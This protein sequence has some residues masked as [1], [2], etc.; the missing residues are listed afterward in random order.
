MS[1]RALGV[2]CGQNR[3]VHLL[4]L[5]VQLPRS[6]CPVELAR[7]QVPLCRIRCHS[8]GEIHRLVQTRQALGLDVA[9]ALRDAHLTL[10]ACG[11]EALLSGLGLSLALLKCALG[12]NHLP[13]HLLVELVF[14]FVQ[15]VGEVLLG[16]FDLTAELLNVLRRLCILHD[17]GLIARFALAGGDVDLA[18]WMDTRLLRGDPILADVSENGYARRLLAD[19]ARRLSVQ[20]SQAGLAGVPRALPFAALGCSTALRRFVSATLHVGVIPLVCAPYRVTSCHCPV[21]V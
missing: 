3:L 6:F 14:V 7:I 20:A 8:W 11:A 2:G 5:Q 12:L 1:V 13:R 19:R 21:I 15:L 9:R 18:A 10:A 17:H 16:C 4:C